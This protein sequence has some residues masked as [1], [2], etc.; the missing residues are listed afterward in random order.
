MTDKDYNPEE[1]LEFPCEYQF[2]VIGA[3]GDD[4]RHAVV[5]TVD[6]HSPVVTDAIKCRP[7]AQ[8]KYQSVS[9]L[10]T[11]HNYQQLTR[12]YA[13]LKQLADVKMLL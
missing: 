2:K 5:T 9:I 4:F 8:G 3:A 1:L 13:D 12:I 6:S 10:V 11:L 7:S